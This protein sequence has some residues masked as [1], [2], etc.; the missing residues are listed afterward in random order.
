METRP[1]TTSDRLKQLMKERNMKQ[2]DVLE[3]IEPF[4][5]AYNVHFGK[6]T[7][8]Q[9]VSGKTEPGQDKLSILGLAFNVNEAWLM[10]YAVQ[11][12]RKMPTSENRDGLDAEMMT[13]FALLTDQEKK[14]IIA[15]TK[16]VL[17]SR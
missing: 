10:G 2:V 14:I 17:S 3:L 16:G 15:Q 7:I 6:S 4:C 1:Y 9:Y 13:L 11:R 5:K 12:E 8:S